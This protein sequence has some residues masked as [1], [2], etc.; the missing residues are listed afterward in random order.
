M[1]ETIIMIG[2]IILFI[3]L[4]TMFVSSVPNETDKKNLIA[5]CGNRGGEL[6]KSFNKITIKCL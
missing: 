1:K 5:V 2:S 4:F 6:H 3:G